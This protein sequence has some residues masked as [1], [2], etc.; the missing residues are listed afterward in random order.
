MLTRFILR[1]LKNIRSWKRLNSIIDY[2]NNKIFKSGKRDFKNCGNYGE[3]YSGA[4]LN[5]SYF[6]I[7]KER[8]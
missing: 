7:F 4:I 6:T 3:L 2:K 8:K 5:F 1:I